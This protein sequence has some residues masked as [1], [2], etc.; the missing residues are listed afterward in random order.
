MHRLAPAAAAAAALALAVTG[1]AA[2]PAAAAHLNWE[3][4]RYTG[5]ASDSHGGGIFGSRDTGGNPNAVSGLFGHGCEASIYHDA[6]TRYVY[7]YNRTQDNPVY[8]CESV[9]PRPDI[10]IGLIDGQGCRRY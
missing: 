1:I 8:Y 2:Q 5:H 9:Y 6:D 10:E 3:C 7:L 4:D